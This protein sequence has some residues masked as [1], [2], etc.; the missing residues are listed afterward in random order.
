[1]VIESVNS[2]VSEKVFAV[3]VAHPS[4]YI[5]TEIKPNK[6]FAEKTLT[7]WA[8]YSNNML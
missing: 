6:Q 5:A 4:D 8:K 2:A 7:V 1:M 3:T